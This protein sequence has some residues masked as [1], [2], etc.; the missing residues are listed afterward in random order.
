LPRVLAPAQVAA[1]LAAVT[2]VK[3]RALFTCQYGAG[4]RINEACCLRV[5][6]VDSRRMVLRVRYGKGGRERY[7][8]LPPSLLALLRDYWREARPA[9]WLFPGGA[10][11]QPV[12]RE[13]AALVFRRA[14]VAA[15]LGPW[16]TTH[17]LRHSFATHLLEAGTDLRVIQTLLGH[18]S[19]RTTALYTHVDAA[20]LAKVVSPL[21][22]LPAAART[23]VAPAGATP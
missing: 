5:D 19:I 1:L 21:E 6:D 13:T 16:C 17:V 3:Y 4:L 12:T 18:G 23:P 10:A 14:R 2:G 9:T 20:L 22:R 15:G 8:L 7:S 11:D